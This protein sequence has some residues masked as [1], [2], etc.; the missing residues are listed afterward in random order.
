MTLGAQ[1]GL[2]CSPYVPEDVDVEGM[3]AGLTVLGEPACVIHLGGEPWACVIEV[4]G[5]RRL[6]MW[7]GVSQHAAV[8]KVVAL[9]REQGLRVDA[10]RGPGHVWVAGVPVWVNYA[11][12]GPAPEDCLVLLAHPSRRTR[13]LRRDLVRGV[14]L[15]R[16]ERRRERY[17]FDP[18]W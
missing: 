9:A 2:F 17:D 7:S 1:L 3:L 10:G 16:R 14:R 6:M 4:A 5:V 8:S 13:A 15:W 12:H 11:P 18:A